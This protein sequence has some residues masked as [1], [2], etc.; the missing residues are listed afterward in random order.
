MDRM[1]MVGG[2][3][4]QLRETFLRM[5]A[6]VDGQNRSDP[7]YLAMAPRVSSGQRCEA[8]EAALQLVLRGRETPNGY[9]EPVLHAARA[10][11]KS[12]EGAGK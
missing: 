5:A 2:S 1:Q 11:V 3:C 10:A 12:R 6:V 8:F 9:T 4:P 7:K